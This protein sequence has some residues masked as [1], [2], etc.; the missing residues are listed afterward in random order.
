MK[1]FWLSMVVITLV[2]LFGPTALHAQKFYTN[3]TPMTFAHNMNNYWTVF[4]VDVT[5]FCDGTPEDKFFAPPP[6][7]SGRGGDDEVSS[8]GAECAHA[9]DEMENMCMRP[10]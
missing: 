5:R 4:K 3:A 1:R 2:S 7:Y 10:F 8:I 6:G 9:A